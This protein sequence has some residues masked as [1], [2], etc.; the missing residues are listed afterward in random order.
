MKMRAPKKETHMGHRK[1]ELK[2]KKRAKGIPRVVVTSDPNRK[3]VKWSMRTDT[4]GGTSQRGKMRL[5]DF[6]VG[7]LW[8]FYCY[9]CCYHVKR[10]FLILFKNLEG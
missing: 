2:H 1:Q 8:W 10:N 7:L 6:F 3:E 5:E 4:L 9:C